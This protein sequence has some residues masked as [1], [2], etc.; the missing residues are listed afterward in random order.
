MNTHTQKKNLMSEQLYTQRHNRVCKVIRWHICKNVD[1]PVPENLCEHE[2]K[3]ITENMEVPLTYD[4]MI[5][6][7]VNIKHKA[8]RP[9]ITLR[10]K[11]ERRRHC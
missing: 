2:P 9:D 5:P 11:K 6:S 8:L 3:A 7:G 10:Y 4:L 1:I